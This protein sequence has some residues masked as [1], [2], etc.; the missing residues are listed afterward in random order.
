MI[1]VIQSDFARL[2]AE[3]TAGEEEAQKQYDGF[4]TDSSTDKAAKSADL[5][6]KSS[7]KQSQEQTLSEKQ[8][9]LEGTQKELDA[10][11]SYYENLVARRKEEIESLQEALKILSGEDLALLQH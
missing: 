5:D 7:K 9:D 3:T 1:E 4:M 6:Q 2:E 10:A 11:M 8:S